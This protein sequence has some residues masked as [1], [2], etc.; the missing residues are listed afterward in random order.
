MNR[1]HVEGILAEAEAIARSFDFPIDEAVY[2]KAERDPKVPILFAGNLGAPVAILGRDLGK[3]E[4]AAGQPL[5]GAG[6]KLV[7]R[8][9]YQ[10]H[11]GPLPPGKTPDL[12]AM[13]DHVLLT[14]TVPF[15]PPGNKAYSES[16]KRCF[17]PA[18]TRL[19]VE[20]WR[21]DHLFTLGTEAFAWFRP[22]LGEEA[23][24]AFWAREDRYEA[25]LPCE[26]ILAD[27]RSKSIVL[28][29]LP[30][31]SPLNQ[32]WFGAFPGLLRSRLRRIG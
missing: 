18:L 5:V 13:L 8:E 2:L 23:A 16:I 11:V 22:H 15:K 28:G 7:R 19:L 26:I 17:R 4:V 29:P 6:G 14:N 21:G 27:G 12:S 9:V 32:R 31:P 25:D 20:A 1:P 30:H 24:E 3:D 10:E